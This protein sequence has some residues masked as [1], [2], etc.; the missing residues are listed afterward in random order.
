[1]K[2]AIDC[3]ALEKKNWAGKEKYLIINRKSMWRKPIDEEH[4]ISFH[5]Y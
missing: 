2:I 4:P 1:M 5:K 3:R